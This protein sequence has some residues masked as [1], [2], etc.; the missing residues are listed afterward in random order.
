MGDEQHD[1]K[2]PVVEKTKVNVLYETETSL[3][4]DAKADYPYT[5]SNSIYS[6]ILNRNE[7]VKDAKRLKTFLELRDKYVK[8]EVLFEDPLFPAN[9]SSLFYSSK[10]LMKI[11]WKRPSVSARLQSSCPFG[12][13]ALNA[14]ESLTCLHSLFSQICV[15][16]HFLHATWLECRVRAAAR[17]TTHCVRLSP[18]RIADS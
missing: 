18:S 9:D 16:Y 6:A 8:K 11:D 3:Q 7:A 17:F 4:L 5:G 1:G 15:S 13:V 14:N 12:Q 2:V 10:P